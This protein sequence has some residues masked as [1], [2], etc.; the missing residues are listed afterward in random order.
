MPYGV[1]S[2]R[3]LRN[4]RGVNSSR[5]RLGDMACYFTTETRRHGEIRDLAC[6]VSPCLRGE[7]EKLSQLGGGVHQHVRRVGLLGGEA[8]AAVYLDEELGEAQGLHDGARRM[9]GLVGEHGEG[10]LQRPPAVARQAK[11]GE[12]VLDAG[13]DRGVVEFV[14]AVVGEEE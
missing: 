9:H 7:L 12:R 13:V 6:S 4:S 10:A 1:L 11:G 5:A 2:A 14:L 8:V 3:S